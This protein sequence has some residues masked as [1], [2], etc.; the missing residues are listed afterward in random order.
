V[1]LA[2]DLDDSIVT[3]ELP[4]AL[5]IRTATDDQ[6]AHARIGTMRRPNGAEEN[7]STFFGP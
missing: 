4:Q 5:N 1:P 3:G 6:T 2:E 7:M